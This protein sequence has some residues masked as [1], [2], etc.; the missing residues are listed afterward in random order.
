MLT[1]SA[2]VAPTVTRHVAVTPE[3][4]AAVAVIKASP[5]DIAVTRPSALT[6]A[7]ASLL[8]DHVTSL[9]VAVSGM[10]VAESRI[11][12]DTCNAAVSRLSTMDDTGVDNTVTITSVFTP[13]PSTA[14]TVTTARPSLTAVTFPSASTFTIVSSLLLQDKFL[15]EA[16][17]GSTVATS[18]ALSVTLSDNSEG[19]TFIEVT[20]TSVTVTLQV[21]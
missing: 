14:V 7:T 4:S 10:T 6:V 5:R 13:E 18:R 21:A 3:P 15:F 9:F 12:P 16:V 11:V 1:P 20:G 8:D 19:T 2:G 17:S